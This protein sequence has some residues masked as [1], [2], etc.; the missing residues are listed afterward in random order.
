MKT[1]YMVYAYSNFIK[2]IV[3][4]EPYTGITLQSNHIIEHLSDMGNAFYGRD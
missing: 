2:Y 4:K 3:A 1:I